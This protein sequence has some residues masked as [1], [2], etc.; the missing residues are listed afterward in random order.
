MNSLSI[1]LFTVNSKKLKSSGFGV[2]P[3]LSFLVFISISGSLAGD[4]LKVRH[5]TRK[6]ALVRRPV[7]LLVSSIV[8]RFRGYERIRK[9]K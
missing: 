9:A 7:T 8:V 3:T 4:S 1:D 2:T 6:G 5:F